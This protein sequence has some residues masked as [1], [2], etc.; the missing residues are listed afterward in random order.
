MKTNKLMI[1]L[2]S[3]ALIAL[4][5]TSCEEMEDEYGSPSRDFQVKGVVTDEAGNPIENI[6]VI[7]RDAYN[8]GY[9]PD[10]TYTDSQG[11]FSSNIIRDY[12]FRDNQAAYFDDID[13][14]ANG[15]TFQSD[16]TSLND[17]QSKQI[18][19]GDGNWYEGKYEFE[20]QQ[21]LKKEGTN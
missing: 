17:M 7:I 13:G 19:K 9:S 16:S 6:R 10:T 21:K 20:V 8:Y 11:N 18:E 3:G 4:G 15:G 12:G 5:F 1:R 14:D 2:L